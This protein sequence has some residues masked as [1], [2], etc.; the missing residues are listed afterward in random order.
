MGHPRSVGAKKMSAAE[1][2]R[3]LRLAIVEL[4]NVMI[5]DFKDVKVS[6]S[7]SNIDDPQEHLEYIRRAIESLHDSLEDK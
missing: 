2:K 6:R 3:S 5:H 1:M 4:E 7:W